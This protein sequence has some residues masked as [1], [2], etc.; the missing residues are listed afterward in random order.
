MKIEK[1]TL[2]VA[3][4]L[5]AVVLAVGYYAVQYNKQSSIEK[6]QQIKIEQERQELLAE[7][8]AKEE[9]KQELDTCIA[10]AD[11]NYSNQWRREC[12]AQGELT[13]KCIDINELDYNEYL[14]KYGLTSEE[15]VK[16]RNLTPKDPD[17]SFSVSI[18]AIRDYYDRRVNE[19]SC[20]LAT[21]NADSINEY[22]EQS[23]AECFKKYPQ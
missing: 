17:G 3:I 7:Q 5:S 16:Q 2:P 15:Y 22:W 12:K 11:E 19:C 1:I 18:S 8:Q 4:L 21:Y 20:R 23:K 13:S 6:Q 9:T 10:T 14:K